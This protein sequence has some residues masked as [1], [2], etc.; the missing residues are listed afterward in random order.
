MQTITMLS[1][2]CAFLVLA[3]LGLAVYTR[4]AAENTRAA[5]YDE[6]SAHSQYAAAERIRELTHTIAHQRHQATVERSEYN[7][8]LEAIMQDADARIC[9]FARRTNPFTADDQAVLSAIASKLELAASTFDGL[10]SPDHARFSRTLQQ[11]AL[12][13]IE[14]LRVAL[15]HSAA[16][17]AHFEHPDTTL[18]EWLDKEASYNGDEESAELRF[19]VTSPQDGFEHLRDVLRLAIRQ[20]QAQEAGQGVLA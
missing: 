11:N 16:T 2:I 13:M 7:Q 20:Q 15:E 4:L 9:L 14:R 5:S 10:K 6:G 8:G 19:P 17:P 1:V 18:I 12:N 3:L